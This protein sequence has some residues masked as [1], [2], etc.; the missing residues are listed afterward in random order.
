MGAPQDR[1]AGETPS[2]RADGAS[3]TLRVIGAAILVPCFA[4]LAV[5]AA[6]TP[7]ARGYGTHEQLG[8]PACGF[9]ARTGWPCPSCGLTTSVT[10][11]VHGHIVTAFW[12]QPFGVVLCAALALF[13]VV[14]LAQLVSGKDIV[15]KLRP[16]IWWVWL[17]IGT[18][19]AGWGFE[20]ARRMSM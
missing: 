12:V 7:D 13:G 4:I 19:L 15:G 11:T 5:G 20:L 10:N 8:L 1:Q 18:F 9:L 16:A 2:G 3:A 14:G 6:L 17:V